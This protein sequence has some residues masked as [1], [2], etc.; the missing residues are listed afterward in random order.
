[1]RTLRSELSPRKII[2]FFI[3]IACFVLCFW[4]YDREKI[5]TISIQ[6]SQ[7]KVIHLSMPKKDRDRLDFLFR[8]LV[9]QECFGYTMLG[10]KPVSFG[11]YIKVFKCS[12]YSPR[13]IFF[14]NLKIYLGWKTWEKYEKQLPFSRFTIRRELNPLVLDKDVRLIFL[15]D[16]IKAQ[17]TIEAHRTDFVEILGEN[18]SIETLLEKKTL[19]SKGLKKHEGLLGIL[20]GYGA[21]NSWAFYNRELDVLRPIWDENTFA[22]EFGKGEKLG[23]PLEESLMLPSFMVV[24]PDSEETKLLRKDF[25][26]T[27]Q[28]IIDYYKG[29]DFLEATLS[30]L[31]GS[32][33]S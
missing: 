4:I 16:K 7:E 25:I 29:K 1:M 14:E 6:N 2:Y 17:R 28:K 13:P 27:R 12:K 26:Q 11:A 22:I 20:L 9:S 3:L 33:N 30:L 31:M 21:A 23:G 15:V 24:D 18:T 32:P 19:F 8:K 10:N 5:V